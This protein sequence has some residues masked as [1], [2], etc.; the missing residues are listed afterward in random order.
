MMVTQDEIDA[1]TEL[2]ERILEVVQN[3][4]PG[5]TNDIAIMM[6]AVAFVIGEVYATNNHLTET[7]L[8]QSM[9]M[10]RDETVDVFRFHRE[11]MTLEKQ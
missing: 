11:H 2:S 10:L 8:I 9:E 6:E 3:T 4:T 1:G 5:T 7:D